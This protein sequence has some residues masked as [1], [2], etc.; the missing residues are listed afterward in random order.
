M[1]HQIRGAERR[2]FKDG[3]RPNARYKMPENTAAGETA[4]EIAAK[5]NYIKIGGIKK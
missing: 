5:P 2:K 4:A 3:G 1:L